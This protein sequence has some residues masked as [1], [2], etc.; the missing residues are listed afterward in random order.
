MTTLTCSIEGCERPSRGRGLCSSHWTSWARSSDERPRCRIAGCDRAAISRGWCNSHYLQWRLHG[1][2][3]H[4]KPR[5]RR[6]P[7]QQFADGYVVN[8]ETGCWEWTKDRWA[9]GYGVIRHSYK[10]IVAHRLAYEMHKGSI[11]ADSEVDHICR[12]R[13]CVNPVH[14]RLATRQQNAENLGRNSN[15]SS[16]YRGVSW[17]KASSTWRV[18]VGHSGRQYSGGYFHDVEEANRAAVEL[19]NR[20]MT[21]NI[22]R[23]EG[24]A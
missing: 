20:L 16:G 23:E 14:L 6:P 12:N 2:P 18:T 4:G 3:T 21:Y 8:P 19:R 9:S 17:H 13:A 22:E 7:E 24:A 11:P 5:D 10:R 1:D 15:N